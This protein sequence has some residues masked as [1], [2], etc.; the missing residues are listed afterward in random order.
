MEAFVGYSDGIGDVCSLAGIFPRGWNRAA[1]AGGYLDNP[2]CNLISGERT[3]ELPTLRIT[4]INISTS[5]THPTKSV[6]LRSKRAATSHNR[7]STRVSITPYIFPR[8]T[9]SLHHRSFSKNR[10]SP[11]VPKNRF[12][13]THSYRQTPFEDSTRT[14]IASPAKRTEEIYIYKGKQW[15]QR[16]GSR[17]GCSLSSTSLS[18][19]TA[20]TCL[21][22]GRSLPFVCY[23]LPFL[24]YPTESV[25]CQRNI[26]LTSF[27]RKNRLH[28]L[29]PLQPH[30]H[31]RDALPPAPHLLPRRPRMVLHQR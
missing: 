16:E 25:P 4:I 28:L 23:P 19:P 5:P 2:H 10:A 14:S 29:P 18:L 6:I 13:H 8:W 7:H 1:W 21:R 17:S 12:Q 9:F 24:F 31:R 3:F 20:C 15:G 22:H 30:L 26:P 11:E 27:S